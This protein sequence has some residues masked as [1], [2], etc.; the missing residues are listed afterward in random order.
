MSWW[1]IPLQIV[2]SVVGGIMD[3]EAAD[4]AADAERAGQ[5]K[6]IALSRDIYKD[7]R[8][9]AIPNYL[10]GGAATNKLAALFGIGPQN[11]EAAAYGD[12]TGIAGSGGYDWD[13]YLANN[14]DL[15]A[16]WQRLSVNKKNT[17]KT[18]QEYAQWHY[19]NYGQR[20]GRQLTNKGGGTYST[21]A[22][23]G[24]PS[25]GGGNALA[26]PMQ[27]FWNSGYGKL[28]TEGFLNEDTPAVNAAFA[29]GGMALSGAQKKALYDRGRAR[30]Y[31]AF[32]DYGNALRSLAG[33]NQ[34][35]GSAIAGAGDTYG[36]RAGTALG[37]IG[38]INADKTR[39]L[40][41]N[42]K[43]GIGNALGSF[44]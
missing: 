18:P 32:S 30:S 5:D 27:D 43:K 4:D 40:N 44:Y 17:F 6:Q 34:T 36:A 11:Y 8:G 42:W 21:R 39:E 15:A 2:G 1:E 29:T 10:T 20:E 12:P 14:P 26:D 24:A 28:S 41:S 9:L 22:P 19:Q 31:G 13:S 25:G 37:N 38:T 3:N 33:M 23:G 35:A 7:Q 16:E